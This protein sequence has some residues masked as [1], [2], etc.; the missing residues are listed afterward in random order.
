MTRKTTR[1]RTARP[2]VNLP[3]FPWETTVTHRGR[4]YATARPDLIEA[5]VITGTT[6]TAAGDITV[7]K[8]RVWRT[9]LPPACA[10]LPAPCQAALLHYAEVAEAVVASGGT[11]DPTGGGGSRPV[12]TG[13]S[14]SKIKAAEALGAMRLA[15]AEGVVILRRPGRG[16]RTVTVAWVDMIEAAALGGHDCTTMARAALSTPAPSARQVAHLT[17]GLRAAAEAL[18]AHCGFTA[19]AERRATPRGV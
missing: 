5:D 16:A 14:L 9:P 17:A 12:P 8:A 11:S 15:L 6:R 7:T 13:P 19:G 2:K 3:P 10:H 4:K 1:H 18:A